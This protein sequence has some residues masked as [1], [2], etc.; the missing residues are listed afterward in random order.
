M[1]DDNNPAPPVACTLDPE[2]RARVRDC[3]NDVGLLL[4]KEDFELLVRGVGDSM[5]VFLA[6]TPR[7]TFRGAHD[8]LR[9]LWELSHDDDPPVAVLRARIKALPGAAIEYVDGRT[10]I[11][12][13]RLFPDEGP[14]TRF[15]E[16]AITADPEK[17]ILAS[18][19][20]E[21]R[22]LA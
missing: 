16:W 10:P 8:A 15:Q 22:S 21:S 13:E 17:L 4:A 18:R 3:L 6:A 11:V 7:G 12:I 9:E 14:V 20:T 5:G 1:T 19:L 2:Q